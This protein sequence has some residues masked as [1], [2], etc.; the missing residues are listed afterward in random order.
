[1]T[2]NA[3]TD[4]IK[5]VVNQEGVIRAQSMT[6]RNGVVVLAG[7]PEGIVSV[8]GTIDASGHSI[9]SPLEGEGQGE[10][11]LKGGTVQVTGQYVGLFDGHINASGD[12]GGGT[13]LVGGDFQGKNP[14]VQNAFRTYVSP[15][16]TINAD[17]VTNGN[18]GKVIVWADD[19]TRY[20]GSISAR[21]GAQGG[22]GGFVEVSGKQTL[23]FNGKVDTTAPHGTTGTLL[24][25]PTTLQI[26]DGAAV[27]ND[28]SG[29]AADGTVLAGDADG[30]ATN[31]VAELTLEGLAGTTNVI[32]EATGQI[33]VSDL[34]DGLL[35]M[36]QTGGAANF[37]MTS[38][39]S[40]GIT[41][42]DATN[43]IRTQGGN[44]TLQAQG[45]GNLSNIG[46][47]T[48]NGGAITLESAT[49]IGLN[50]AIN[51]SSGAIS[52]TTTLGTITQNAGATITGGTGGIT[53][54]AGGAASDISLGANVSAVG[55]T[56]TM[57][58]GND[59]TQSAGTITGN[60]VSLTASNAVDGDVG[61]AVT[62][63]NTAAA[64]L[65]LV[66][67]GTGDVVVTESD[68]ATLSSATTGSGVVTVVST[69]GNLT[70]ATVT[71]SGTVT[72][73]ALAGSV[74]DDGTAANITGGTTNVTATGVGNN[75]GTAA[76]PLDIDG[77]G[78]TVTL[79][80]SG[81]AV[82][83]NT[84]TAGNVEF[85]AS[86]DNGTDI[87]TSFTQGG[88]TY[89]ATYVDGAA[90]HF[91]VRANGNILD[92]AA[93]TVRVPTATLT[94]TSSAAAGSIGAGG[95]P[96]LTTAGTLAFTGTGTGEV[97]IT[98]SDGATVGGTTGGGQVTVVSTTGNLSVGTLNAGAGNV[99][100]T[101]T[102][103][104]I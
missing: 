47:L 45:T 82:H 61:T 65:T 63:I 38:T 52:I 44:I 78:G 102:A 100:L 64:S 28:L 8:S 57:N 96:I 80:A 41:F 33:T 85:T 25:D 46:K 66:G 58:A 31:G 20:Y 5:S 97:V 29:N 93:V 26:T 71:T 90:G 3:A 15:D 51:A 37:R 43:E 7:G 68:S 98:E 79:T 11:G 76:N 81:G 88:Q 49:T 94:L 4:V 75:I 77:P 2:A 67:T 40:G 10:G 24:L 54:T 99:T 35:N 22:D 83:V 39:T 36:A 95:T 12:A 86:T 104:D 84:V 9:P 60:T 70:V 48:S 42:V 53:V 13:V 103:G 87:T 34:T 73:T 1:L 17:A 18:G 91:T 89:N 69:T 30:V 16:S 74:L 72:L 32:R 14:D 55:G 59:I 62:P 101:A 92:T 56:V 21:G 27:A 23:D 50:G 19:V 6:E